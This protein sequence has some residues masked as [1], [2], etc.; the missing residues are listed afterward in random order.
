MISE[1]TEIP[2]ELYDELHRKVAMYD[3]LIAAGVDNWEGT[4]LAIQIFEAF[5]KT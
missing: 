4:D 5:Y 2:I 3:A 1:M